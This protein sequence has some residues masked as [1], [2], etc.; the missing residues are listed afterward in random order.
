MA[1]GSSV[2]S[3]RPATRRVSCHVR[4]GYR[5]DHY[6]SVPVDGRRPDTVQGVRPPQTPAWPASPACPRVADTCRPDGGGSGSCGRSIRRWFQLVTTSS[7]LPQGQP[8]GGRLWRPSSAANTC[9]LASTADASGRAWTDGR[10]PATGHVP[11]LLRGPAA[12]LVAGA[13][14]STWPQPR[15]PADTALVSDSGDTP[16]FRRQLGAVGG[17]WRSRRATAE[18]ACGHPAARGRLG[19]WAPATMA[20]YA[21]TAASGSRLDS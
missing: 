8:A 10:L 11:A 16:G 3:S 18:E 14:A 9:A 4:G 7:T 21:D 17:H 15:C 12:V 13:P 19:L 6:V 1:C 2:P 20:G 5:R